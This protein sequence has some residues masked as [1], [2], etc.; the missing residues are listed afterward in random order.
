MR[1]PIA[2]DETFATML[3]AEHGVV[4]APGS[5]LGAGGEGHV[6][7]ALVPT[8]ERCTEAAARLVA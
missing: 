3:L 2:D 7:I 6:R 1:T 4:V 8:I 5:F